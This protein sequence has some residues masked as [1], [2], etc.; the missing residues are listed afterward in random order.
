M[1]DLRIEL[2][3]GLDAG[4][5]V[6]V[7][8]AGGEEI[9]FGDEDAFD[10]PGMAT[11][12]IAEADTIFEDDDVPD[13]ELE[14]DDYAETVPTVA[15]TPRRVAVAAAEEESEGM[16]MLLAILLTSLI[17]V[18]GIPVALDL[19]SD[20]VSGPSQTILGLFTDYEPPAN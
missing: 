13:V 8:P 4:T 5:D 10:D 3:G 7:D 12:E 6:V 1:E 11:E 9:V 15:A 17:M 20:T 16:G 14:E 19:S 18:A 2:T